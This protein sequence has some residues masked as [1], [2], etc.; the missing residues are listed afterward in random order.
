MKT[1][2][3]QIDKAAQNVIST[4]DPKILSNLLKNQQNESNAMFDRVY[5]ECQFEKHSLFGQLFHLYVF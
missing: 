5:K 4:K 2:S 1:A 3:A